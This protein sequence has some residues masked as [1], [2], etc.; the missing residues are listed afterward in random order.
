MPLHLPPEMECV[1]PGIIYS[2]WGIEHTIG[3]LG[4]EIKQHSDPF[5]NLAQCGLHQCQVNALKA[6]IPDLEPLKK[7]LPCGALNL[8]DEYALLQAMDN[9]ARVVWPC[10]EEAFIKYSAAFDHAPL[11]LKVLCWA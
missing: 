5:S 1:G 8:G 6:L 7:P 9:V 10:K 4:E 11:S 3:N 2:Q